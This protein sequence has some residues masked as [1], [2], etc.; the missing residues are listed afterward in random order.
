[1]GRAR[2]HVRTALAGAIL[3]GVPSAIARALGHGDP[4]GATREI[5][6]F[7][8]GRPTLVAGAAGHLA[9][10]T[11]LAV[12]A[13]WLARARSPAFAGAL[14]GAL[15]YSVDFELLAPRLWPELLRH[16]GVVQAADHLAFG[17]V[18]ATLSPHRGPAPLLDVAVGGRRRT[19]Y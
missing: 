12:P 14:Y 6:R 16:G 10:S 15:L 19:G 13:P 11:V 1:V 2:R 5:G 8:L 18:I 4:L 9:I 3:S 17:I 7:W